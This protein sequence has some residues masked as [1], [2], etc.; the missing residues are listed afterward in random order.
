MYMFMYWVSPTVIYRTSRGLKHN[1]ITQNIY[2][3]SCTFTD[4]MPIEKWEL[5]AVPNTKNYT[6]HTSRDNVSDL[7]NG[8]QCPLCLRDF[9]IISHVTSPRSFLIYDIVTLRKMLYITI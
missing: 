7:E 6:S 4:I 9:L 5:F 8:M 1:D 3:K 2:I